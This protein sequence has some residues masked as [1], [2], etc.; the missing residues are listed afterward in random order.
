MNESAAVTSQLL[1]AFY[2]SRGIDPLAFRCPKR[3]G[4]AKGASNFGEARAAL[5]G[6]QYGDPIRLVVVS[7]DRGT[8]YEAPRERTLQAVRSRNKPERIQRISRNGH[9]YRTHVTV[10]TIL[11]RFSDGELLPDEVVQRFV[12]TNSVRCCLYDGTK[13]ETPSRFLTRCKDY[14][15]DELAILRPGIVVTQGR[16]AEAAMPAR[17]PG[18]VRLQDQEFYWIRLTHPTDR[19]GSF[20]REAKGLLPSQIERAFAWWGTRDPA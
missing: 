12:H 20:A 2:K 5:V 3:D 13:S 6:E 4:C 14:L 7:S 10:A 17:R 18:V 16:R 19:R 11:S 1:D 9:W 15:P 8:G